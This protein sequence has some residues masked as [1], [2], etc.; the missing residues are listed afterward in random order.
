MKAD[1]AEAGMLM[2]GKK[3]VWQRGIIMPPFA[4]TAKHAFPQTFAT[5]K[6]Y[7]SCVWQNQRFAKHTKLPNMARLANARAAGVGVLR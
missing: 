6:P 5:G 7:V 3:D 4:K 1:A 2:F